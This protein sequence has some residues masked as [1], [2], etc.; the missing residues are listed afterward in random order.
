MATR[1][2][3]GRLDVVHATGQPIFVT[4]VSVAVA[5]PD[6]AHLAAAKAAFD[7][8]CGGL[9][10][11]R[12]RP[13]EYK[14]TDAILNCGLL[15]DLMII[16]RVTG[17]DGPDVLALNTALFETCAPVLVCLPYAPQSFGTLVA[18]VWSPTEQA[19]RAVRAAMPFL[20]RA[21]VVSVLTDNSNEDARPEPL[22]DYLSAYGINAVSVPFDGDQLT[23]RGRGRAILAATQ[24]RADLLVMGAYGENMLSQLMGLGRATQK[25]VTATHI[26]TLI[27]N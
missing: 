16:E 8:I 4:P 25:V 19:A 12:W 10:F 15:T 22:M 20:E 5:E 7:D 13:S 1:K 18:V 23:A 24:G 3:G 17:E 21:E 6:S 2:V 26:P 9:D 27:H 14:L 11:V